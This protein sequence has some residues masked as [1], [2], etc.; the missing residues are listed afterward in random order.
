MGSQHSDSRMMQ[1]G[2]R[3][4]FKIGD[5]SVYGR[6]S[7]L[8]NGEALIESWDG[9]LQKHNHIIKNVE[10]QNEP[11]RKETK[12]NAPTV[13]LREERKAH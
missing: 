11:R 1:I 10:Y 3:G 12:A 4:V 6:V 2:D 13:P 8:E 7:K 9:N 5:K